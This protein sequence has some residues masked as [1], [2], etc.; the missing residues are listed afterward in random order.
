M[1]AWVAMTLR[2]SLG[3]YAALAGRA[4]GSRRAARWP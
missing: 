4:G 2:G 3:A 1:I